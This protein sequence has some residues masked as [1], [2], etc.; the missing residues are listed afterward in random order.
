MRAWSATII[1]TMYGKLI[2][3]RTGSA[4]NSYM[5][6]LLSAYGKAKIGSCAAFILLL[7]ISS[8][9]EEAGSVVKIKCLERLMTAAAQASTNMV[10]TFAFSGLMNNGG[11]DGRVE[12]SVARNSR[13]ISDFD[14]DFMGCI[15]TFHNDADTLMIESIPPEIQGLEFEGGC[16]DLSNMGAFDNVRGLKIDFAGLNVDFMGL[17]KRFPLVETLI[18]ESPKLNNVNFNLD[19]LL[20]LKRLKRLYLAYCLHGNLS[21]DELVQRIVQGSHQIDTFRIRETCYVG[22]VKKGKI[23]K[24]HLKF[25]LSDVLLTNKTNVVQ[26]PDF[27]DSTS[28]EVAISSKEIRRVEFLPQSS[29]KKLYAL[30]LALRN[31]IPF[32]ETNLIDNGFVHYDIHM[33]R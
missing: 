7:Y 10:S 1:K 33:R 12:V 15:A 25:E 29:G 17:C 16:F 21:V 19:C 32:G 2:R 26:I 14:D 18:L 24:S 30:D 8:Y 4:E 11:D 20:R 27:G 5:K 23:E 9:G 31:V 6:C 13:M 28:C 3:L 22:D